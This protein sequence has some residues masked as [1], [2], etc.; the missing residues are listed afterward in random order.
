[1]NSTR[2]YIR[3]AI[4]ALTVGYAIFFSNK[5]NEEK[6]S[7]IIFS[8]SPKILEKQPS[9]AAN[10][11]AEQ[12]APV[13]EVTANQISSKSEKWEER[14]FNNYLEKTLA[15]VPIQ[16]DLQKLTGEQAHHSPSVVM[17]VGMRLGKIK[18]QVK[19]NQDFSAKA[20]VFYESCA[21]KKGA[22]TPVRG[23][24]LA[25][26]IYLKKDSGEDLN[27]ETFPKDVRALAKQASEFN[28]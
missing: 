24:C 25:N 18:K 20:S 7:P 6:V 22:M 15:T 14:F 21:Q 11:Q 3:V 10:I 17:E 8:T 13:I 16:R 4:L 23:L 9:K 19:L 1:M 2:N 28:F 26:L 5:E 12:E 27:L